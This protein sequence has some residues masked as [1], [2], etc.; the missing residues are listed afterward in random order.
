MKKLLTFTAIIGILVLGFY[1]Y[2]HYIGRFQTSENERH[3]ISADVPSPFDGVRIVQISDLLVRREECL[4]LLEQAVEAIN[5]LNPEIIIFTGN[6]F[7]PEGLQFEHQ[8]RQH[9]NQLNASLI[10]IAVFGYHDLPH[11]ELTYDVLRGADF[12]ILN[13]DSLQIFNQSPIGI[14]MIGAFPTNDRETMEQLLEIHTMDNRLNLLLVSMPTF[15]TVAFDYPILAQ[16]SGHCL[17]TQNLTYPE[18]ACFQF[19]DGIYQFADT[20]TLNVSSGLARFHTISGLFRQPS[21]DSFL[22]IRD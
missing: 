16:F 17:G 11:Y 19:Y 3:I 15:S 13:N 5:V 1:F 4:E 10:Q 8:V 21:I 6:L 20:F 14:N 2:F 7:M 12:R 18:A 22:L 9:L